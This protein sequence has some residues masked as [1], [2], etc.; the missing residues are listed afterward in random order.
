MVSVFHLTHV[1]PNQQYILRGLK[2]D[3]NARVDS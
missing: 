2:A 3:L 1:L